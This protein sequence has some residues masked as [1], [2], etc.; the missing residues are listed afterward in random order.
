MNENSNGTN[1]LQN[2]YYFLKNKYKYYG[3]KMVR[4]KSHFY[5]IFE[6][7]F[8]KKEATLFFEVELKN[9]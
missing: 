6:T 4:M 5:G 1:F 7:I 3:K 9:S 8:E 2:F